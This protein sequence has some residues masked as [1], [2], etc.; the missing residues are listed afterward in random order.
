[1][2]CRRGRDERR[3]LVEGPLGAILFLEADASDGRFSLVE[4]PL[5][6]RALGAP[7]HTHSREDGY[8]FVLEGTIG[9]EI[10]GAAFEAG[11]GELVLKQRG[12]P[13]AF[14]NPTDRPALILELIVPGG[15]ERYFAEL[16]E[17]LAQPGPPDLAALGGVA[18]RYGLAME[19]ESIGRLARERGLVVPA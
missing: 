3:T 9:V 5:A 10:D 18:A 14:W 16:G 4:H 7:V 12:V 2:T 8:S 17:I 13:H 11:P 15:F 1:M 19:P 6:P